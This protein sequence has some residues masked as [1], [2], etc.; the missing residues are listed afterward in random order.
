LR[1]EEIYL[2]LDDVL[3]CFT[4]QVGFNVGL[5]SDPRDISWFP[6]ECGYELWAGVCLA[7]ARAEI[8]NPW[9]TE[10]VFWEYLGASEFWAS[11]RVSDVAPML[12]AEACEIV[13]H[14]NVYIASATPMCS[15]AIG[16]K[17]RWIQDYIPSHLHNQVIL[18]RPKW[19]LA[20]YGRLLIDDAPHNHK[21][22]QQAGGTALLVPK[23]W[24]CENYEN[25]DDTAFLA[26]E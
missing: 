3:N 22:W 4:G 17:V 2:D 8:T 6:H 16:H 13:G 10:A 11:L 18:G 21:R 1:I 19:K 25:G 5:S 14:P 26:G 15:N 23:P 20:G 12:I 9:G 24:N 7:L